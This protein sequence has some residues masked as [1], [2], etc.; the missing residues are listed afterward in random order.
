MTIPAGLLATI[1]GVSLV[2]ACWARP[3]SA[4]LAPFAPD[5]SRGFAG[6]DLLGAIAGAPLVGTFRCRLERRT[7][8]RARDST[9][10]SG[11]SS[12]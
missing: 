12:A 7:R 11:S 1:A 2:A 8:S 4:V 5:R 9:G 6:R 3:R 10:P